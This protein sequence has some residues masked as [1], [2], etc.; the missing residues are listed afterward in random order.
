[1]RL[2]L[3]RDASQ[4]RGEV[5]ITDAVL[6][7]GAC[8]TLAIVL[9]E[10]AHTL[11]KHRGVTDTS[12]HGRYHNGRFRQVAEELGLEAEARDPSIGWSLTKLAPGVATRYAG[13]VAHLAAVL[14]ERAAMTIADDDEPTAATVLSCDCGVF[15]RGARRRALPARGVLC[16][17]CRAAT[18]SF[19]PI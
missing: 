17:S 12:S 7:R 8:E 2:Q 15:H 14:D 6:A 5:L 11:A 16:S 3:S 13:P 18:S 9:H 4:L 1:V 19:L 10:A